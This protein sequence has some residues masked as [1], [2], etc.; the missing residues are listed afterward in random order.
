[1]VTAT[2]SVRGG[3]ASS[4]AKSGGANGVSLAQTLGKCGASLKQALFSR[5]SAVIALLL[6]AARFAM[7]AVYVQYNDRD[8]LMPIKSDE[9]CTKLRNLFKYPFHNKEIF[10]YISY[11]LIRNI[12]V[13]IL[14]FDAL[15]IVLFELSF[16]SAHSLMFY[17]DLTNH[18]LPL[19]NDPNSLFIPIISHIICEIVFK[20]F[21]VKYATDLSSSEHLRTRG[22]SKNVRHSDDAQLHE[23]MFSRFVSIYNNLFSIESGDS[24]SRGVFL[25]LL[26][27]NKIIQL[28][29]SKDNIF[30][31]YLWL[32]HGATFLFQSIKSIQSARREDNL[33]TISSYCNDQFIEKNEYPLSPALHALH[34]CQCFI[35]DLFY[36]NLSIYYAATSKFVHA[37]FVQLFTYG[38]LIFSLLVSYSVLPNP[39]NKINIGRNSKR[40]LKNTMLL[41]FSPYVLVQ[42]ALYVTVALMA[43]QRSTYPLINVDNIMIHHLVN[44]L[45][46]S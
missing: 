26:I 3:G 1:V 7:L 37:S 33:K 6:V 43:N 32:I 35:F 39:L 5:R 31:G 24:E 18:F 15:Y 34:L 4:S 28:N 40:T 23:I 9:I 14:N 12:S 45:F 16:L 29:A 42:V 22:S 8:N 17:L 46:L 2:R 27:A 30:D 36:S 20:Q 38:V 11:M 25:T 10:V 13:N 21:L 41:L 44:L 19:F